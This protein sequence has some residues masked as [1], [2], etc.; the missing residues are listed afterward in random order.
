MFEQ[1]YI[2]EHLERTFCYKCGSS[3]EG[4]KLITISEA[5]IALVA[6]AVC[7]KCQAESMVTITSMGSGVSPVISDLTGEELKRFISA[8]AV[9]Y[10]DLFNLHKTLEKETIWKLLQKK[11]KN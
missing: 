9:N 11:E 10:E 3:L 8:R 2:K 6:H 7:P 1:K 5:P 4:A